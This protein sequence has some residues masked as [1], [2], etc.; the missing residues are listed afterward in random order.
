MGPRGAK[1]SVQSVV[2]QIARDA[3]PE[4]TPAQSRF[5]IRRGLIDAESKLVYPILRRWLDEY[6]E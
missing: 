4:L 6:S 2:E 5:L 1:F 3:T